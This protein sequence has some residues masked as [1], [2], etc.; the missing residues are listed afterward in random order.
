MY[1]GGGVFA[2]GV[3]FVILNLFQHLIALHAL[4]TRG[5]NYINI[6]EILF[7]HFERM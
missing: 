6:P 2:E 7:G 4:A 3:S 1:D 5:R